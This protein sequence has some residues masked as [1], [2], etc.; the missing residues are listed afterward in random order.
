MALS[1]VKTWTAEVLTASDLNAE[2]NN[3]INNG[4]SL[5]SPLTGTLD[6]DNNRVDDINAGSVSDPSINPNGD[7]NT[8]IYF[9]GAD[10]LNITTGGSMAAEFGAQAVIAAAPEDSRTNTV[11]IA[12]IL[13]STTS[14]TPADGIGTGLQFDAESANEN[15]SVLGSLQFLFTDKGAGAEDSDFLVF[16]REGGATAAERFRIASDGTTTITGSQLIVSETDS[17]TD[18]VDIAAILRSVTS[19]TPDTGIG[20][21]IQFDAESADENPSVLGSL[22][23]SFSDKGAGAEDSDF[24]IFLREAGATAAERFKVASDGTT[25]ITGS[26]LIVSETDS[27][28]DAV[29]VAAILRSVTSGTPAAGIGTGIQFDAESADE[30]PCVLGRLDFAATDIGSGSEDTY[31][32]LLLRVAG[33]AAETKYRFASTAG[34]GFQGTLTHA[35]SADR[36]WTLPDET[37]TLSVGT[38]GESGTWAVYSINA[39]TVYQVGSKWRRI[40]VRI[41]GASTGEN[42]YSVTAG[43]SSPPGTTLLNPFIDVAANSAAHQVPCFFIIPGDWYFKVTVTTGAL[44]SATYMD[45]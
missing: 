16:L 36:T 31:V 26:Q 5:V 27:R 24:K 41:A 30:N 18:A 43:A 34:S 17:R 25:T 10:T 14:G 32:D 23:F 9:S 3:I 35:A 28:T 45:E 6:L 15:P 11:D 33:R 13:R 39:G 22:Q 37:G 1:R 44:D 38:A 40:N 19:G 42:Q 2:F 12:A 29:D 8:G 4:L 21:G 20:T 7:S